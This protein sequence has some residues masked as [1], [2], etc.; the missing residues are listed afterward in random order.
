LLMQILGSHPQPF[1]RPIGNASAMWCSI[2]SI[3]SL[4]VM[5]Q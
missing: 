5:R 4:G 1:K 2:H 3:A